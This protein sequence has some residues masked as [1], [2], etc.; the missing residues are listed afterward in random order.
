MAQ[1]YQHT[2]CVPFQERVSAQDP[3]AG[4]HPRSPAE[5]HLTGQAAVTFPV[6]S[7]VGHRSSSW[8]LAV[9]SLACGIRWGS[10]PTETVAL[11]CGALA[12]SSGAA[13]NSTCVLTGGSCLGSPTAT[14]QVPADAY[15]TAHGVCR[16]KGL[17]LIL[18]AFT[19]NR[20]NF[21]SCCL[22]Q[23]V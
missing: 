14:C 4:K 3:A 17:C 8:T 16:E 18:L 20:E 7:S 19:F 6:T 13:I 23:P 21:P 22:T 1:I 2:W 5:L 9:P 12:G 15:L 11:R 10:E